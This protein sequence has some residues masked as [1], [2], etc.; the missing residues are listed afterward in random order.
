MDTIFRVIFLSRLD[1]LP[2]DKQ[3]GRITRK[4]IDYILG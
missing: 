4:Y 1:L 3:T 2:Q